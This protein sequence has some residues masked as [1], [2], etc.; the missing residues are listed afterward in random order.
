M[1]TVEKLITK[2]KEGGGGGSIVKAIL[3]L[4]SSYTPVD[5]C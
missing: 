3:T 4:Q 5:I 2:K 1:T